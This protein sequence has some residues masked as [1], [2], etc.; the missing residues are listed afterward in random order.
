MRWVKNLQ[1]EASAVRSMIPLLRTRPWL[2]FALIALGV[3]ASLV[4][5]IGLSLFIPFLESIDGGGFETERGRWFTE[6]LVGLFRNVPPE[7]RLLFISACILTSL[8]LKAG[9][10]YGYEALFGWLDVQIGRASCRER[11]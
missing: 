8:V 10:T 5:G 4:E 11:V 7:Q 9:L 3:L 1:E 2:L 6:A